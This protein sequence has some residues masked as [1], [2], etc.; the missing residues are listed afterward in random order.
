MVSVL[1]S[2][3]EGPETEGEHNEDSVSP[4]SS[5][6]ATGGGG[7][8]INQSLAANPHAKSSIGFPLADQN[9]VSF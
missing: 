2:V 4:T 5:L 6:P 9:G 7:L 8:N 3:T 1:C